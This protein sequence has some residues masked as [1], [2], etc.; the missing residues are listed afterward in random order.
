MIL[1]AS[2]LAALPGSDRIL[3]WFRILSGS[4]L[5]LAGALQLR[6]GIILRRRHRTELLRAVATAASALER[7]RREELRPGQC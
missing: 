3:M 2:Q 7:R 1:G 5:M 4:A 6:E